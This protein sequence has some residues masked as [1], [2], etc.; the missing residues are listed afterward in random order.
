MTRLSD[1]PDPVPDD[2][3]DEATRYFDEVAL[4][5]LL[6]A[7]GLIQE[8]KAEKAAAAIKA[9]LSS[10]AMVLRGGE[11]KTILAEEV[12]QGD[13]EPKAR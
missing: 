10:H 13:I 9:M 11:R 7:I 12:V 2:V 1:R 4:A 5:S 6:V 8:G 3:W